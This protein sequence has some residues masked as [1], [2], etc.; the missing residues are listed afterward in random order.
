MATVEELYRQAR[1]DVARMATPD[2]D[3]E[4]RKIWV[5]IGALSDAFWRR[6]AEPGFSIFQA[7]L[8]NMKRYTPESADEITIWDELTAPHNYPA[9]VRYVEH[10]MGHVSDYAA[11]LHATILDAAGR[12]YESEGNQVDS[13]PTG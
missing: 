12:R 1:D 4:A 7:M 9:V 2:L 8:R 10:R 5:L 11:Q 3:S 6:A 13:P